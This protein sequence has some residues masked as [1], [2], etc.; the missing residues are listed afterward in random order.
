[1][2]DRD[3]SDIFDEGPN[4]YGQPLGFLLPQSREE[5]RAKNAQRRASLESRPGSLSDQ[6]Q[7]SKK[8]MGLRGV[9]ALHGLPPTLTDLPD[10][11]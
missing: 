9:E 2:S 4:V 5:R 11:V 10:S 1:M 8:A 7:L 3:E 6:T